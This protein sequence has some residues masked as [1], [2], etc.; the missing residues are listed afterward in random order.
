MLP[1][2]SSTSSK[3]KI[4][5]RIAHQAAYLQKCR[6]TISSR[7]VGTQATAFKAYAQAL[8]V[9][10]AHPQV[11]GRAWKVGCSKTV[12]CSM[13]ALAA[14]T[15]RTPLLNPILRAVTA[16][17]SLMACSI[18]VIRSARLLP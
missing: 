15:A 12:T 2:P 7:C 14:G 10:P 18:T 11:L 16:R 3:V 4:I 9:Q 8:P 13:R 5:M 1:L 17:S 6:R